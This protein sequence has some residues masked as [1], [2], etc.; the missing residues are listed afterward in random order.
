MVELM[1]KFLKYILISFFII[2]VFSL[3][4]GYLLSKP[5]H[6][7]SNLHPKFFVIFLTNLNIHVRSIIYSFLSFGIYSFYFVFI[8]FFVVGI[9]IGG[10]ATS[11]NSLL[12]S[13]SFFWIHGIFELS[14]VILTASIFPFFLLSITFLILK[15]EVN[16]KVLLK[17][18]KIIFWVI[19]ATFILILLSAVLETFIAPRFI[20]F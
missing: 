8:H 7:N 11:T 2:G 1:G 4:F 10:I 5:T 19:S 9:S 18:L 12:S 15:K 16:K 17:L 6:P 13:L 20:I 3:I 14:T